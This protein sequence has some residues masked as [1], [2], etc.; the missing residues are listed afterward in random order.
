MEEDGRPQPPVRTHSRKI[1]VGES[2]YL[3]LANDI[4]CHGEERNMARGA[5]TNADARTFALF[6]PGL[7]VFEDVGER[8]PLLTTKRMS[9]TTIAKE[10]CWFVR[11]CT[12]N[13]VLNAQD[14][15]IWDDNCSSAWLASVGLGGYESGDVG[16]IY[17]FQWRHWG[18]LYRGKRVDY[19]GEGIDQLA[20]AVDLLR[21][22][23]H[24]RRNKVTAWNPSDIDKMCLPPCHGDFQLSVRQGGLV[25]LSMTQRSADVALGLPYN[26]ASYAALLIL[27]AHMAGLRAGDLILK[28]EDAHIY[29]KHPD[30]LRVQMARTPLAPPRLAIKARDDQSAA[31]TFDNFT[32]DDFVLS[33][34]DAPH[35]R[36]TFAMVP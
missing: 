12:D 35:A 17:G 20:R 32:H 11:G 28:V 1:Y 30:N 7:L 33:G 31:L 6:A 15:H 8:F 34:Y 26:I 24:T 25:D 2:G 3:E 13:G 16:P 27:V 19:S 18:A 9:F 14:V 29:A 4:L 22:Q 10:L 36:L 21:T 5:A 23:P